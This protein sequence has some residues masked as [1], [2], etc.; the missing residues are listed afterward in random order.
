MRQ[1]PR[2]YFVASSLPRR[3]VWLGLSIGVILLGCG[4]YSSGSY[5]DPT[6]SLSAAERERL[7]AFVEE[8]RRGYE[9][10]NV[11]AIESLIQREGMPENMMQMTRRH[12]LPKGPMKVLDVR[13]E[14]RPQHVDRIVRLAGVDYEFNVDPLGAI[15][16][17]M[18][19]VSI[20]PTQVDLIIG[21]KNGSFF[22]AGLKPLE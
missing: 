14:A 22:I 10:G 12:A 20:G 19:D 1:P 11:R 17:E 9:T 7:T 18:D 5:E 4:D 15:V 13:V 16:I 2:F 21:R 6:T 8:V 3:L